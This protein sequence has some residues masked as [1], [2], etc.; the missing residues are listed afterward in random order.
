MVE[1]APKHYSLMQWTTTLSW[2]KR[3][4]KHKTPVADRCPFM[5]A[6]ATYKLKC[7]QTNV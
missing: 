6:V 1:I 3:V 5:V 2:A 4:S 7:N